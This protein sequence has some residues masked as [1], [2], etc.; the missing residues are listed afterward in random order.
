M[1]IGHISITV[2]QYADGR[3]G[4]DDRSSGQ[5]KMVRLLSKQKAEQRA[6]DLAVL[7]ANGRGDLLQTN[8]AELAQ[9]RQWKAEAKD[10]PTLADACA[11]FIALK[12]GKSSRHLRSLTSD[13]AL[14][15]TFI[16]STQP[17]G[18]IK[19][20]DIQRFISSRDVGQ[21]RQFN[22]RVA[23]VSLFRWARRMSYLPDR[24][25]E[26]ERVEPIEKMPGQANVLTPD[27]MQTLLD[28]VRAEYLPWL[29]MAA[30]AGVRI[31]RN[32]A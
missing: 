20:L 22:L 31:R 1:R 29:V 17:I 9:F 16:G 15:E 6:T 30:F 4:F 14:F 28:N 24:T 32:C 18:A 26:A 23:V 19:A 13:L 27:Q 5:R 3:W 10:S 8:A 21:R 11:E 25:T 12:K 7:M 2:R